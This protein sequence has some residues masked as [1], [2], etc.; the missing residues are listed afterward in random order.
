MPGDPATFLLLDMIF[1]AASIGMAVEVETPVVISTQKNGF[2]DLGDRSGKSIRGRSW[3]HK[4][5]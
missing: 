3:I 1:C 5:H 4:G 2:R